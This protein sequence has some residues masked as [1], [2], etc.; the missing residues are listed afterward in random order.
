MIGYSGPQCAVSILPPY[1]KGQPYNLCLTSSVSL[2][3]LFKY[4]LS[5]SP[6]VVPSQA[7]ELCSHTAGEGD[8]TESGSVR[9]GETR[10]SVSHRH[11]EKATDTGVLRYTN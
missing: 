8:A 3:I 7:N 4:T 9:R 5:F 6:R 10:C 11:R 1:S 2:I